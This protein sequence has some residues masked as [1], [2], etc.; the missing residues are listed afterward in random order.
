MNNEAE[1]LELF[2]IPVLKMELPDDVQD[3]LEEYYTP[4]IPH[5]GQG[6]RQ[7]SD[8]IT[9]MGE[10]CGQQY[11]FHEDL[12]NAVKGLA[13]QLQV[14][15]NC[16]PNLALG[17]YWMQDYSGEGMCHPPHTHP[18]SVMSGVYVIRSDHNANPLMLFDPLEVRKHQ[19]C[20]EYKEC[21]ESKRGCLYLFPA[22]LLHAVP[23]SVGQTTRTTLAFN[24]GINYN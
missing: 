8:Y 2:P 5:N 19:A 14:R 15:L 22:F 20:S 18:N 4:F 6:A 12:Q 11:D 23:G 1:L 13:E 21:L 3:R 16:N 24:I 10:Y 7:S 17:N 9:T